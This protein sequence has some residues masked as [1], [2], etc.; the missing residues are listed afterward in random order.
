MQAGPFPKRRRTVTNKKVVNVESSEEESG[1]GFK[2]PKSWKDVKPDNMD[3]FMWVE[4]MRLQERMTL[5]LEAV[6]ASGL[7]ARPVASGSGP[8]QREQVFAALERQ[9]AEDAQMRK[10]KKP[11][12]EESDEDE[13]EGGKGKR[14]GEG[15]DEEDEGEE[16]LRQD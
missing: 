12:D 13:E 8:S 6:L 14:K 5:A 1:T 4:T 3:L 10:R 7:L 2:A 11:S 15:S 9:E 16:E